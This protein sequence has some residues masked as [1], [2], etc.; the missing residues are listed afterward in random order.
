MWGPLFTITRLIDCKLYIVMSNIWSQSTLISV[1]LTAIYSNFI[2]DAISAV[3]GI[4]GVSLFNLGQFF[5]NWIFRAI[6]IQFGVTWIRFTFN[7]VKTKCRRFSSSITFLYYQCN[8]LSLKLSA[9]YSWWDS[10][11]RVWFMKCLLP[12]DIFP[13]NKQSAI[14]LSPILK[15]CCFMPEVGVNRHP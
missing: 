15:K 4:F 2:F 13:G 12:F 6:Q 7:F 5:V 11:Y 8:G 9:T 1:L 3:D 14:T 10:K